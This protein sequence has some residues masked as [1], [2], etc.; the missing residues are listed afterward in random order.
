MDDLKKSG[1]K[2]LIVDLRG[3]I[4]GGLG[5]LRLMS[6][7][8]PGKIPVGYSVTR[9]RLRSGYCKE[10]L[11]RIDS[12]PSSKLGLLGMALRF[13]ILNKDRSLALVTEG[14]GLQP[15]HGQLAILQN[16]FTHSA[17]E[18]VSAFAA[19]NRLASIV[20]TRSAGE[21]LG[22]ANFGLPVGYSLRMPVAAWLTWPGSA[23][24][25][26]AVGPAIEITPTVDE[27][28]SGA[29]PLLKRVL[30]GSSAGQ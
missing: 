24:E 3:N 19:E 22:G 4:G 25:G 18:M 7:L 14:L 15:F 27:W 1:C 29:D 9:A 8:C 5:S 21:V 13:R 16:E 11:P 26:T 23:I 30:E 10:D 17:A 2:R 6:Y 12:I 28:S 20:G